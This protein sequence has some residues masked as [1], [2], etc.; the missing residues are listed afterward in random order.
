MNKQLLAWAAGFI[1]GEGTISFN[2]QTGKYRH[3]SYAIKLSAVNTYKPSLK[4]LQSLFGGSI[5]AMHTGKELYGTKW[6]P[7]FCWALG[8]KA[9]E[10]ALCLLKPFIFIKRKQLHLALQARTIVRCRALNRRGCRLTQQDIK[11]SESY[12]IKFRCL[13][14][15]GLG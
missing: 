13:N 2:K 9:S 11:K 4:R 14:K 7:S 5:C 8:A 1:D 6:K 3:A 12:L 15:K 10:T